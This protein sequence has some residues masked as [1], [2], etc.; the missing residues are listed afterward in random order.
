MDSPTQQDP[1]QR[2]ALLCKQGYSGRGEELLAAAASLIVKKIDR[3]LPEASAPLQAR[4]HARR[5]S[6]GPTVQRVYPHADTVP[7]GF[8]PGRALQH[9]PPVLQAS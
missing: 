4:R 8:A 5:G 7:Y 3:Q 9:A 1:Y 6:S 2:A